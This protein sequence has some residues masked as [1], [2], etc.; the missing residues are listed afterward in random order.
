M[1]SR[2]SVT[3]AAALHVQIT[4]RDFDDKAL[5]FLESKEPSDAT[6]VLERFRSNNPAAMNNKCERTSLL[7]INNNYAHRICCR[8][9]HLPY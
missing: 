7:A 1:T 4:W 9:P 6:R 5:R 3:V 2:R 8:Q